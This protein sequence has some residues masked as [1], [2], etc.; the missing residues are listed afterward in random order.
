M[1]T[2]RAQVERHEEPAEQQQGENG[3]ELELRGR[4]RARSAAAGEPD[5]V[6]GADVRRE[7]RGADD[8]PTGVAAGEE[9]LGRIRAVR[10]AVAED[11]GVQHDEVRRDDEP[12][13]G[14]EQVHCY[15]SLLDYG[16]SST[17]S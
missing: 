8:E 12:V 7:D 17:L 2:P 10:G 16:R 13:G 11:D 15:R 6:L 9:E 5:E 4:E 1:N 14:G 3:D